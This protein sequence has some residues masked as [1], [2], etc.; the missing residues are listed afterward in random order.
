VIA[1]GGGVARSPKGVE[2]RPVSLAAGHAAHRNL[3]AKT[4]VRIVAAAGWQV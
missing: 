3:G 1:G 4:A 2:R